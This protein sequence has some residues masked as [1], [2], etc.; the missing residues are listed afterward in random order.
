[1][2][3]SSCGSEAL[4]SAMAAASTFSRFSFILPLLSMIRPIETGTSSR[5][6]TFTRCSTPSSNAWKAL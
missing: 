4:T 3:T 1:M 2:K 6:K 5:R